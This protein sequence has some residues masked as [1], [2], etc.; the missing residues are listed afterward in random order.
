[1]IFK[2]GKT[3]RMNVFIRYRNIESQE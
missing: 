1:M 3:E 2:D